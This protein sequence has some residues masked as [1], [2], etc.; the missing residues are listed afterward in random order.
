MNG[1]FMRSVTQAKILSY[2]TNDRAIAFSDRAASRK[3]R[4]KNVIKILQ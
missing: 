3:K 4:H 1:K 2:L